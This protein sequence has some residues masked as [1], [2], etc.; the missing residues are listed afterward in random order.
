MRKNVIGLMLVLALLLAISSGNTVFAESTEKK[1]SEKEKTE[2]A[3][4]G[5]V[6]SDYIE[7]DEKT[8]IKMKKEKIYSL[9]L[10]EIGN[11]Y[12]FEV[13][14]IDIM[15]FAIVLND[16]VDTLIAEVS[17][18]DNFPYILKGGINLYYGQGGY[19]ELLDGVVY[20]SLSNVYLDYEDLLQGLYGMVAPA[21]P[22]GPP[23][24]L[25]VE[26][27][28]SYYSRILKPT[29]TLPNEFPL[30]SS[31]IKDV[32]SYTNNCSP[33]AGTEI[34][35]YFDYYYPILIDG[36]TAIFEGDGTYYDF[37]D[38]QNNNVSISVLSDL[39]DELYVDM[40]TENWYIPFVNI[41]MLGTYPRFFFEGL[42]DYVDDRGLFIETFSIRGNENAPIPIG[43]NGPLSNDEWEEYKDQIDNG[44]PVVIQLGTDLTTQE[45]TYLD[46][47]DNDFSIDDSIYT[48][49]V[50]SV[51]GTDFYYSTITEYYTNPI[52]TAHTAVGYGY[53]DIEYYRVEPVLP[54]GNIYL[55]KTDEFLVVANGWGDYS[56]FNRL[57]DDTFAIM[58]AI[59]IFDKEVP[60]VSITNVSDY[61]L[62]TIFTTVVGDLDNTIDYSKS[63]IEIYEENVL[64]D[65]QSLSSGSN[66]EGF[67]GLTMDTDYE[68][69]ITVYYDTGDGNGEKILI[70]MR[71]ITTLG[72]GGF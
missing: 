25:T 19:L 3:I 72:L 8:K 51:G 48:N 20:D 40:Y 2:I 24:D 50:V 39:H 18:T 12:K 35:N 16:G 36:Y 62:K 66:I 61:P 13:K 34:L 27:E 31:N 69:I 42:E 43:G 63:V 23:D 46:D 57:A 49:T 30:L 29:V 55:S 10:D 58:Y 11:V 22:D 59:N 7:C 5:I 1:I 33:T 6:C 67:Y 45:Y 53:K 14:E 4:F 52:N 70:I 44:N 15:G 68:I 26:E 38:Y 41:D 37:E 47:P 54:D 21:I 71:D 28:Y 56:Y 32:E 65:S 60:T 17:V 64:I 9:E